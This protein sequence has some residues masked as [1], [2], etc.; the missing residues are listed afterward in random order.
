MLLERAENFINLFRCEIS[1]PVVDIHTSQ[2]D[3]RALKN[4]SAEHADKMDIKTRMRCYFCQCK[5]EIVLL[6]HL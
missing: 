2:R 3:S 1:V 6:I 4:K 5:Y